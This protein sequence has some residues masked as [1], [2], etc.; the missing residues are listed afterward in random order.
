LPIP[1]ATA[2]ATVSAASTAIPSAVLAPPPAPPPPVM[3]EVLVSVSPPDAVL[4]RD[5]KDLGGSPV[6]VHLADGETATVVVSRKGYKTKSVI[7]DGGDA[8]VSVSL[9]SMFGPPPRGTGGG[10]K[11]AGGGID[12][13]GD[14]FAKKR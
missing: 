13:V 14:P 11:P 7:I 2:T 3:H 6:A 8:K 5:G 12:D 1:S 10:G 9:D 4:K